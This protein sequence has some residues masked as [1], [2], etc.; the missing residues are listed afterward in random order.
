MLA[1]D[2]REEEAEL[3]QEEERTCVDGRPPASG[4]VVQDGAQGREAFVPKDLAAAHARYAAKFARRRARTAGV[5][6]GGLHRTSF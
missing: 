5:R 2:G 6:L 1:E 4:Y 3:L